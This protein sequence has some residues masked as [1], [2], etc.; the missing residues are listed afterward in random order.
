VHQL[1]NRQ[2]SLERKVGLDLNLELR[3]HV[4]G[5]ARQ[6][7]EQTRRVCRESWSRFTYLLLLLVL[8]KGK[9]A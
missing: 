9:G 4:L 3:N 5:H 7:T 2:K 1:W 8:G 6:L